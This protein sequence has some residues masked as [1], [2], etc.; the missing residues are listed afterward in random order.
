M[1]T[2]SKTLLVLGADA[3][4]LLGLSI[5]GTNFNETCSERIMRTRS[6]GVAARTFCSATPATICCSVMPATTR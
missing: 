1:A 2:F 3:T 4:E 6:A 5:N